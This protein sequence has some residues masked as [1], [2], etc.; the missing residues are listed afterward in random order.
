[1][2]EPFV[3]FAPARQN[4][5]DS[6]KSP[7][8]QPKSAAPTPPAVPVFQAVPVPAPAT[9]PAHKDH[10]KGTPPQVTLQRE[11]DRVT[12]IQIRCSCG[13]V[14]ELKCVY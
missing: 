13:E 3:P 6:S 12:A 11:G 14:I 10:A 4:V 7:G 9:S 2:S 1:M 8:F 5:G